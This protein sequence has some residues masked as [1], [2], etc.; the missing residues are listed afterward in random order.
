M[1]GVKMTTVKTL[2]CL[3]LF[4]AFSFALGDGDAWSFQFQTDTTG[5]VMTPFVEEGALDPSSVNT[6]ALRESP[7][8]VDFY[9]PV[10]TW[11]GSDNTSIGAIARYSDVGFST[12]YCSVVF[13]P[14]QGGFLASEKNLCARIGVLEQYTPNILTPTFVS[15]LLKSTYFNITLRPVVPLVCG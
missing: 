10:T 1:T 15:F 8:L 4:F 12:A 9:V 14:G 7:Y 3:I 11:V 2:G 13:S 6:G 5:R